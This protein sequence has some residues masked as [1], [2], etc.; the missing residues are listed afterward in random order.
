MMRWTLLASAAVTAAAVVAPASRAASYLALGV[1]EVVAELRRAAKTHRGRQGFDRVEACLAESECEAR[2]RYALVAAL[3]AD[4]FGCLASLDADVDECLG[5]AVRG[6]TLEL[7]E[8]VAVRDAGDALASL[9]E[10]V[11]GID[12]LALDPEAV[13]AARCEP[14]PDAIEDGRLA[15]AVFPALAA[16][17]RRE[18]LARSTIEKSKAKALEGLALADAG[19]FLELDGR[20][21]VAVTRAPRGGLVHGASRSGR[22]LFVEP[23]ALV[24][25]TNAWKAALAGVRGEET[26]AL[27][28]LSCAV[29]N[30]SAA[31]EKCLLQAAVVDGVAARAKVGRRLNGEIPEVASGV[32][33]TASN[34]RHAL[35]ESP[36]GNDVRLGDPTRCLVISGANA[37]GKTV[38]LKAIGLAA[39]LVKLGVPVPARGATVG[40][41]DPILA[42][43]GDAQELG[44]TST[45]VGHLRIVDAALRAARPGALVLL[46]ELGSG[47]DPVQGAALARAVLERLVEEGALCVA[48]THHAPLKDF[49]TNNNDAGFEVAAMTTD[50]EGRPTFR[51]EYGMSGESRALEAA[52]RVPLPC[53]VVDRAKDILGTEES[54]LDDLARDLEVAIADARRAEAE[55]VAAREE[56]SDA[57]RE[58]R[59]ARDRADKETAQARA[60]AA[61]IYQSRLE[62]LEANLAALE[63]TETKRDALR[64]QREAAETEAQASN[65]QAKGLE[66]LTAIPDLKT[67]V[68][69]LKPG[70]GFMQRG[71]VVD[72]ANNNKF[73]RVQIDA[74]Q[75]VTK[76]LKLKPQDLALAPEEE[77]TTTT[78]NRQRSFVR[79]N[80]QYALS[81]RAAYALRDNADLPTPG[82]TTILA[83]DDDRTES[84]IRT[85]ENTLDVR[86]LTLEDAEIQADIF[87]HRLLQQQR[88]RRHPYA[89]IL[90][91]HGTGVLKK[92]LRA[93]AKRQRHVASAK[94]ADSSDGGDAFTEPI[95]TPTRRIVRADPPPLRTKKRRVT[96]IHS[97][98][99]VLEKKEIK[100]LQ[101]MLMAT[102]DDARP[103]TDDALP[104]AAKARKKSDAVVARWKPNRD[105]PATVAP[106]QADYKCAGMLGL[107]ASP[108][109][110]MP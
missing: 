55:A 5:R 53:A 49:A 37:G 34:L 56:A 79:K 41:F 64:E 68:V 1:D 87:L 85:A 81:R 83:A 89:F 27:A 17:R 67:S 95:E 4:D 105:R 30:N 104:A 43:V 101:S 57:I 58:A 77:K 3:P 71:T 76:P 84:R 94:P 7:E 51:C 110:I 2:R 46:D 88:G 25:P 60:D 73:V 38:L 50:S 9:A 28:V 90:H 74:L 66:P 78:K 15:D 24:G 18:R 44:A 80:Q 36:V 20:F 47:T 106:Q 29:R 103:E 14:L 72:R 23:P 108:V 100:R 65:A 16:A 97:R 33:F 102:C 12:G 6:L 45:Y 61:R 52:R 13:R 21:V 62:A 70:L 82:T 98:L 109:V 10:I 99:D 42:H 92:G 8:L 93:W 26:A 59:R 48:T 86:G 40:F 96:A 63:P 69:I 54:R 35:L 31:F 32:R 91:G 107:L 75:A 11:A 39:C 19:E 22:T